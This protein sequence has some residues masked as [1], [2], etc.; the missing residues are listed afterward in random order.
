MGYLPIILALLGFLFLWTIV[1]YQSIR[2]SK[3]EVSQAIDDIFKKAAARNQA[4]KDLSQ[5]ATEEDASSEILAFIRRK[6]DEQ[7]DERLPLAKKLEKEMH[8]DE[9]MGDI[10][11]PSEHTAYEEAYQRLEKVHKQY[12]QSVASYRKRVRDYNELISKNPS[13]LVASLAGFS[14]IKKV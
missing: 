3:N 14:P 6:L 13:R 10:P 11:P 8:L 7:T 2:I 1:N 5:K 9:L 4:L 12:R